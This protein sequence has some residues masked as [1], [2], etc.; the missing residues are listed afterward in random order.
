[1]FAKRLSFLISAG[2]PLIECLDLIR[3][4]TKSKAK[5]KVFE[6]IVSDIARGQ[7]LAT[8]LAKH[9][10]L[11]G[12]FTINII[13]VGET[14]GILSQNLAYLAEELAKKNALKRKVVSALV[15]PVFITV[16]TLGVT[17]LLTVFIFP[18]IMP[19]F[20]SLHVALPLSTKILLAV[21]LYLSQWGILT[22]FLAILF[23][24]GLFVV[25][26]YYPRVQRWG[27]YLILKLPLIGTIVR[28]YNFSNFCRTMGLLLKSGVHLTE[29]LIITADTTANLIYKESYR[30]MAQTVSKGQP[31][32][33]ILDREST[34]YPDSLG[35][36][37]AIGESTGNLSAS[38]LYLAEGFEVEVDD[39]T[40]N[41][42]SSIEPVLML[43]MGVLVGTIAISVITPI[44]D[45]TQHLQPK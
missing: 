2:V 19:I 43:V 41:L 36:L 8:S 3:K 21:S 26:A 6:S 40:K 34:L 32:S 28:A 18:K 5:S 22:L 38:L 24:I 1:M 15:Y 10:K 23:I 13:K 42:S 39:L 25:R 29:A 4:Q 9:G 37:V 20:V 45:I 16:A 44:Y 35:H 11:F 14:S 12:A 31:I 30:R 27:D 7:Y 33:R 17:G